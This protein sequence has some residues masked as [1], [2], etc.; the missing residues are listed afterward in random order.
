MY[1]YRV[2]PEFGFPVQTGQPPGVDQFDLFDVGD[3]TGAGAILISTRD[4]SKTTIVLT[5][6]AAAAVVSLGSNGKGG[7]NEDL[8]TISQAP[9]GTDERVNSDGVT[10]P[11]SPIPHFYA[12]QLTRPTSGS[13][14]DATPGADFCEFDDLVVWIPRVVLINRMVE[15]G[16]LP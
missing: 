10:N 16:L 4:A 3:K 1:R 2:A 7:I 6:D 13:C 12:R 11:V 15:A 9:V 8:N 14:D 5:N